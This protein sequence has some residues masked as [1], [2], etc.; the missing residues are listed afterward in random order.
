MKQSEEP[1]YGLTELELLSL[2]ITEF[3]WAGNRAIIGQ[4]AVAEGEGALPR[5]REKVRRPPAQLPCL[6]VQEIG[7]RAGS[8]PS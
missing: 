3:D 7:L 8:R 5:T 1:N 6:S 4:E 2:P